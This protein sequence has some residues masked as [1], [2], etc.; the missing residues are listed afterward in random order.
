LTEP[1][2]SRRCEPGTSGPRLACG[3][4]PIRVRPI[5]CLP[6]LRRPVQPSSRT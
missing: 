5:A 1:L 3:F 6:A 2:M 4:P